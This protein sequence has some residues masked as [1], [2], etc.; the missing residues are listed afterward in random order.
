M[1]EIEEL[2]LAREVISELEIFL[3]EYQ[4][5]NTMFG[6][7]KSHEQLNMERALLKYYDFKKGELNERD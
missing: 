7:M 2:K 5:N 6:R 1:R 3:G 4:A